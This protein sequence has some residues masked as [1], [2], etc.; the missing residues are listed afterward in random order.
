MN[1]HALKMW[2]KRGR[3]SQEQAIKR[4]GL[5]VTAASWSRW[6]SG[7][8]PIPPEVI[9][10]CTANPLER[11]DNAPELTEGDHIKAALE[12]ADAYIDRATR[13]D[14][15][16]GKECPIKF[17]ISFWY[18][19]AMRVPAWTWGAKG[20]TPCPAAMLALNHRLATAF[21]S[22]AIMAAWTRLDE[23]PP[24]IKAQ[25]AERYATPVQRAP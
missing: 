7:Q 4:T 25:Y 11:A 16:Y 17:A 3:L 18:E 24:R 12:M 15:I 9:A 21:D 10:Y 5:A 22:G 8:N 1:G 2:R 13:I 19:G 6:E 23:C 20:R 14:E